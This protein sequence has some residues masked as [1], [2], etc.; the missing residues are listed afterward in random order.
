MTSTRESE[1][2]QTQI[3]L[4][5]DTIGEE[6]ARDKRS[7]ENKNLLIHIKKKVQRQKNANVSFCE[8]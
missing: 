7:C 8:Q 4:Q 6:R 3:N 1:R 5:P 2:K